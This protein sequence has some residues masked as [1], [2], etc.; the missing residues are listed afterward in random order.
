MWLVAV[1]LLLSCMRFKRT[2]YL[3]P[4]YPGAALLLGCAVEGWLRQAEMARRDLPSGSA[5]S[6][7]RASPA[8]WATWS[9]SPPRPRCGPTGPPFAEEV[10]RR[11]SGHVLFFRAEAHAVAFHVGRPLHTLLEWENLDAWAGKAYPTYVVMPADCAA[12][13]GATCGPAAWSRCCA[14]PT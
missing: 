5:W 10:R 13:A 3:L 2:D 9:L 7:R 11:T 1:L 6:R 4:A 8:G 14:A 12:L